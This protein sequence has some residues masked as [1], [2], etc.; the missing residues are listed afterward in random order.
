[1]KIKYSVRDQY[2]KDTVWTP[3]GKIVL[4]SATQK[5]LESLHKRGHEAVIANEIKG[6]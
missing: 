5:Q 6:E 4:S 3:D 2:K 1:M